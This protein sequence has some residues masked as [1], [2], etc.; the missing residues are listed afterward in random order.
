M[1]E[2]FI[3]TICNGLGVE[4]CEDHP[5]WWGIGYAEMATKFVSETAARQAIAQARNIQFYGPRIEKEE[6]N[7]L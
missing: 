2:R 5:A 3:V 7:L 1:N 4:F 6:R